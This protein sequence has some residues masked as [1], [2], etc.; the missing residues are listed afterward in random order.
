VR[1]CG[2]VDGPNCPTSGKPGKPGTAQV[3]IIVD[4]SHTSYCNGKLLGSASSWNT[5]DTW[6]CSTTDGTYVIAIDGVDGELAVGSGFGGFMASVATDDGRVL[7]SDPSWKCWVP[8]GQEGATGHRSMDPPDGWETIGFDDSEW[9]NAISF[10]FNTDSTTH[11]YPFIRPN[12]VDALG[13]GRGGNRNGLA[14]GVQDKTCADCVGA[15]GGGITDEAQWIWTLEL[16]AHNDVYC[17]G[18]L[19]YNTPA[20]VQLD[21]ADFDLKSSDASV[22]GDVLKVSVTSGSQR[23][24]AFTPV[25]VSIDQAINIQFDM[26]VGDGSGADGL[27]ATLG[28]DDLGNRVAENGVT[29]GFSFCFDEWSNGNAESGIKVRQTFLVSLISLAD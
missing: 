4:N 1:C 10:G 26:Y 21:V 22:D 23:G 13:S 25:D 9:P 24:L 16:D 29:E 27:C 6:P 28:N 14:A 2:D 7:N 11:W 17:R 3:S 8:D 19:D 5:P 12:G 15:V 18:T 20:V